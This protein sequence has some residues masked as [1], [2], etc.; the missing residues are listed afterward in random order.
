MV[1][2]IR[3]LNPPVTAEADVQAMGDDTRGLVPLPLPKVPSVLGKE[4]RESP[5]LEA[6]RAL[7]EFAGRGQDGTRRAASRASAGVPL[8]PEP[9]VP[10]MAEGG[11]D[12]TG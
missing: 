6:A 2:T 5:T 1:Q 8:G 4:D 10:L 11:A 12:R 7:L 9:E 3:G